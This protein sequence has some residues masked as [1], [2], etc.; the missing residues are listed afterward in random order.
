MAIYETKKLERQKEALENILTALVDSITDE[1]KAKLKMKDV[2]T[3][4]NSYMC[5]NAEDYSVCVTFQ[6]ESR[7]DEL[8]KLIIPN[9]EE[10]PKKTKWSILYLW[11]NFNYLSHYISEFI[12]L[13]EG[14]ACSVDKSSW[15]L[16]SYMKW[17]ET[18]ELPD[19][20]ITEKC[21]WKP[22][23]GDAEDWMLWIK[24]YISNCYKPDFS[25]FDLTN[26]LK[27]EG[28]EYKARK[29][30]ERKAEG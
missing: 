8:T 21:F 3:L 1:T 18:E 13:Y 19:M 12:E 26:K 6:L 14:F 15:L 9:Y 17:L 23:F 30:A 2:E 11:K 24:G 28:E 25:F 27:I 10:L 29:L 4:K 7:L 20:T 22:H 16:N 5:K